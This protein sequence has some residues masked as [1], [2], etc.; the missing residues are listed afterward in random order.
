MGD[1]KLCR[2]IPVLRKMLPN[3]GVGRFRDR[4]CSQSTGSRTRANGDV[5]YTVS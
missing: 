2:R 5:P 1:E 4:N 3:V